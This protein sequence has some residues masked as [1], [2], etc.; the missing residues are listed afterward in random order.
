MRS[1]DA[2][3][4]QARTGGAE[5]DT[6]CPQEARRPVSKSIGAK[7]S[8]ERSQE[9]TPNGDTT[10]SSNYRDRDMGEAPLSKAHGRRWGRTKGPK[11]N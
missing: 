7:C 11:Q 5:G 4:R 10:L 6:E 3:V 9:G 1:G 2:P 8:V